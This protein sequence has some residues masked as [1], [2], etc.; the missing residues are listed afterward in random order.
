DRARSQGQVGAVRGEDGD[1]R[2]PFA[3]PRRP[4]GQREL[5]DLDR[6]RGSAAPATSRADVSG[7]AW[8]ARVSRQLLRL[9]SGSRLRRFSLH[10]HASRRSEPDSFC[11]RIGSTRAPVAQRLAKERSKAMKSRVWM[12]V[13]ATGLALTL[14]GT[15]ADDARAQRGG[16]R[17]GGRG[18]GGGGGGAPS[19]EG[20]AANGGLSS[21]TQA[22]R[23]GAGT[24]ARP[25]G[26]STQAS[27][28]GPNAQASQPAA[29]GQASP[30]GT[31]AQAG[32]QQY[33]SSTQASRQQ[34]ASSAQ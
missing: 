18:S 22:S 24:Q 32:R 4:D 27:R 6:G 23:Q 33:Q 21:P 14:L 15:I 7:R 11:R 2:S 25:Q 30:S 16:G 29:S 9:G 10:V 5:P 12:S 20:P 19:R 28:Q 34:Y 3:P 26:S 17:A 1:P 8:P 13:C 31:S